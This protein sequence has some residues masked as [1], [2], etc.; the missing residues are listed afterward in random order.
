MN[1]KTVVNY[2][3]PEK[4]QKNIQKW[5]KSINLHQE[6]KINLNNIF[7]VWC[8]FSFERILHDNDYND[9][10]YNN[11][12]PDFWAFEFNIHHKIKNKEQY[13]WLLDLIWYAYGNK[14]VAFGGFVDEIQM[15]EE[16]K[17]H[18]KILENISKEIQKSSTLFNIPQ[19]TIYSEIY[20]S[21]IP[22]NHA[23]C[24]FGDYFD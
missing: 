1:N 5:T 3:I 21:I 13:R 14:N 6:F 22:P 7:E 8:C 19:K 24:E 4:L 18:V 11:V 23:E 20:K 12:D 16:Y 17:H 10:P 15:S 2:Q 9:Y